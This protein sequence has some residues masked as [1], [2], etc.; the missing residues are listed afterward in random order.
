MI[1]CKIDGCEDSAH[2]IGLCQ[3][4][5]RQERR[6]QRGLSKPGPKRD[7][8]K[9]YSKFRERQTCSAGHAL[10]EDNV[11]LDTRGH[12]L[13]LACLGTSRVI[14]CPH[15]HEYT[16]ENTYVQPNGARTCKT[17]RRERMKERRPRSV[18]QG[19]YN[20]MKMHCPHGHEYSPENTY[21]SSNK[22][23]CRAC[24][25]ENSKR[26]GL[27]RYG[28]TLELCERLLEL[29]D[30][31]CSI[32]GA[33]DPGCIDHDHYCCNGPFSCGRCVRGLLCDKC[34]NGLGRFEDSTERLQAA[35]DYLKN[36]PAY[37]IG[38]DDE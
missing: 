16:E 3:P 19:G 7:P 30:R 33:A 11:K 27:K 23:Q 37:K 21:W 29:Q 17:C 24:A 26:Q 5:Y 32:C 2:A 12:R 28:I 4:H 15:G 18:G 14:Y 13:C 22:R 35:I 20:A 31:K 36:P 8:S 34:N 9:P 1:K 6:R 10:T 38:S 25:R